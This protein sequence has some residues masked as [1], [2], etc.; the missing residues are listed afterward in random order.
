MVIRSYSDQYRAENIFAAWEDLEK[1]STTVYNSLDE[2][3]KPSFY[4]LVHYPVLASSNL[5]KLVSL[6]VLSFVCQAEC[7]ATVHSCRSK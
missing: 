1:S 7:I 5:G 6:P 2:D 3:F 4:Q